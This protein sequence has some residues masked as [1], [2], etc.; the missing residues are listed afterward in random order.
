MEQIKS[1]KQWLR[2]AR[3]DMQKEPNALLS[4]EEIEY[5]NNELQEMKKKLGFKH[6]ILERIVP[7][8]LG[9]TKIDCYLRLT[10]LHHFM[11][12]IT[13]EALKKIREEKKQ[14]AKSE[15]LLTILRKWMF[16]N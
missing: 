12:V 5:F 14:L 3:E 16:E 7:L 10:L 9:E 6:P 15:E 2:Q 8:S 4:K 13:E 1:L 11:E